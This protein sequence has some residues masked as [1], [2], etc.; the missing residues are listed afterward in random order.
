MK[1]GE[2]TFILVLMIPFSNASLKVFSVR[3][4]F[5]KFT[6]TAT[7]A[8]VAGAGGYSQPAAAAR[9]L[10]P[11]SEWAVNQVAVD[12]GNGYCTL[13]RQYETDSV[14][15][16]AR[17]AKGEGT[18]A[19]DFQRSVFDV[20]RPYPVTLRAGDLVRQYVVRPV[21]NSAII[22]RTSTDAS[23]FQ[24]M[25]RSNALEVTIDSETFAIDI[26]GYGDAF[27]KLNGCA[28]VKTPPVAARRE[29]PP[30]SSP[31]S[32]ASP[33]AVTGL[34]SR[35]SASDAEMDRLMA[36]NAALRRTLESERIG[37]R[38]RLQ[39]ANTGTGAAVTASPDRELLQKLAEVENKN[40]EL[41]RRIAGMEQ[42]LSAQTPSFNPDTTSVLAERNSQITM[43]EGENNRLQQML[44]EERRKRVAMEAELAVA[45]AAAG[46]GAPAAQQPSALSDELQ[47]QIAALQE[48]NNALKQALVSARS[49]EPEVIVKEIVKE[50][51]MN[52]DPSAPE[53]EMIMRLAEAQTAAMAARAE[54]DEY[55]ALLQRERGRLREM[56][57]LGQQISGND[58]GQ[59]N[60]TETIRR[61]EA[62]K[63]D[64]L[65]QLEFAKRNANPAA[66]QDNEQALNALQGRLESV[67][68]E[69]AAAKQKL[70]LMSA[71]RQA[72]QAQLEEARAEAA[73]ARQQITASRVDR[74]ANAS[75]DTEIKALES[76]IAAL[77][78][79]NRILRE[80]L[81]A[82]E[83]RSVVSQANTQEIVAAIEDKYA[84]RFAA[85]EQE[86]IRLSRA[87]NA[88]RTKQ[89]QAVEKIVEVERPVYA[90]A[91]TAALPSVSAQQRV[92]PPAVPLRNKIT[93]RPVGAAQ[94][95]VASQRQVAP[96]SPVTESQPAQRQMASLSGDE[97]RQLVMRSDIPLVTGIE[98]VADVSGPD[99]AAFR[100]DT[101][102]VYGSAEQSKLSN[103]RAFEDSVAR[104][105]Q[106]T[107]SRCSGSFDKT[108]VPV[109]S[110]GNLAASAVDIACVGGSGGAAAS[111][112][113]FAHNGMFYAVAHE[114]DLNG[115]QTAMDMRDRLANNLSAVF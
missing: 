84:K 83:N 72:L 42:Q 25:Q 36:E 9:M 104:Y 10:A 39:Q 100:W 86:N 3:R 111:I 102:Q 89:P 20:T 70:E 6:L 79:Q 12:S 105:I 17:N 109:R 38:E 8:L 26:G 88:E 69:S 63:I 32:P 4:S 11:L 93:G 56:A 30:T 43:L 90:P 67:M 2:K 107:E 91:V 98:R 113:F 27:I 75:T 23:L 115:F 33:A 18:I 106:K 60:M 78:A 77:E 62:E 95:A 54:R 74:I 48:Q 13:T 76:E 58:S 51:P 81:A 49:A 65:R 5:L 96:P 71:D 46:N 45:G 57:E 82:R 68:Q 61:L 1:L 85:V 53:S 15:T 22:M 114:T 21:N 110:S 41:L 19:F 66:R 40:A 44:D 94:P 7:I 73:A 59:I 99:F 87:L 28:N 50:V 29:Q 108:L 35:L 24:A 97:I 92:S 37:F 14:V 55:R 16:F 47:Q 64:L 34:Q 52:I 103:P 31:A 101:G 112:L 80:D